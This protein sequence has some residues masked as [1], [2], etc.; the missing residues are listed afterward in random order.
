MTTDA[1][2]EPMTGDE[3]VALTKRHTLFFTNPP[4]PVTEAELR[5]AFAIIDR[6]LAICDRAVRTTPALASPVEGGVGTP[7]PHG[8]SLTTGSQPG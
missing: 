8:G 1:T 4:L 6:G 3:V 7:D 2:R 5:E